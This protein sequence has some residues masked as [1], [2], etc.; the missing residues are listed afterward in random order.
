MKKLLFILCL[1]P[2]LS[3]TCCAQKASAPPSRELPAQV[4]SVVFDGGRGYKYVEKPLYI[5]NKTNVIFQHFNTRKIFYPDMKSFRVLNQVDDSG[6][7]VDKNGIYFQG[8]FIKADTAGIKIIGRDNN[9][10]NYQWLWKNKEK[11]FKNMK[12]VPDVDAASFET[13]ECLNG[14]YFKDKN[15]VYYF[16]KKLKGSDGPSVSKSCEGMC[17]DKNQVYVDGKIA[18]YKGKKLQPVNDALAKT[19]TEVINVPT[20]K[21]VAGI[22]AASLKKLSRQYSMD[23]YH[24]YYGTTKLPVPTARLKNVKVWDQV[25]RAYVSDGVK[26]YITDAKYHDGTLEDKLDAK[27]FGMLPHSDFCFDKNG[28]Y[29]REY[30]EKEQKVILKKF[31]F[32]Y[33]VPLTTENTFITD[34]NYYIVYVNQAYNPW[35]DKI[36]FDLTDKEIEHVKQGGFL[37]DKKNVDVDEEATSLG[38]YYSR[39]GNTVWYM[40]RSELSGIEDVDSFEPINYHYSKDKKNV[41]FLVQ[42]YYG[43]NGW[44]YQMHPIPGAD[45]ATFEVGVLTYD[46]EN[47]YVGTE[48]LTNIS[49]RGIEFL[50]VFSGYRPGCGMDTTPSSNYIFLRNEDGFWVVASTYRMNEKQHIYYLGKTFNPKWNKVFE[51]FEFPAR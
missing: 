12:E 35:D 19:D 50:A 7:A 41:Y 4:D 20:M 48:N 37:S 8:T 28:V 36:Y 18:Q 24:V 45:P 5:K 2:L 15:Y 32:K 42:D 47:V 22:D 38:Y 13:I 1:L 31:P 6:L 11:V 9:Y 33:T 46:K 10:S 25:N 23:K 40:G 34:H 51:D 27:S 16:D 17:Y 3:L 44:V 29:E 49:S 39:K 14:M 43:D 30:I 26:V 21:P